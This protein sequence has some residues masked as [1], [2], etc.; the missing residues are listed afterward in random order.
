MSERLYEQLLQMAAYAASQGSVPP[1][2]NPH[3]PGSIIAGS[4][5]DLV[6]KYLRQVF[7]AWVPMREI[8]R[9]TGLGRGCVGWALR[10]IIC[11][12]LV[13]S[14]ELGGRCN[15]RYLRYRAV[16]NHE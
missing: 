4:G 8:M 3:P 9:H 14:R 15:S 16:V 12:G 13:E 5:T 6:L 7:P 11:E 2:F 10:R 1:K